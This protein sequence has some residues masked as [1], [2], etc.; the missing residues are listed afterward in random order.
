[1][2]ESFEFVDDKRKK[3]KNRGKRGKRGY[4]GPPGPPGPPG[5]LGSNIVHFPVPAIS[6]ASFY[7]EIYNNQD[8]TIDPYISFPFTNYT[9]GH[10]ISKDETRN[11][12]FILEN[13]STK[14][15][16]YQIYFNIDIQVISYTNP[17]I[18]SIDPTNTLSL[19]FKLCLNDINNDNTI[20]QK[21]ITNNNLPLSTQV[22]GNI[23][24]QIKE[25]TNLSLVNTS[26]NNISMVMGSTFN[27]TLS[28]IQ[29]I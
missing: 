7:N 11:N 10:N 19:E 26:D 24:I 21:T 22:N 9:F 2:P 13:N 6:R 15:S 25:K 18:T 16:I 5:P 29:L 12:I 3:N 4:T 17:S 8:N 20:I 28:I 27:S 1:M 14:F 23:I